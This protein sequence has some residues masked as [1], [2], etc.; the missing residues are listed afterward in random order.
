MDAQPKMAAEG[1]F[2]SILIDGLEGSASDILGNITPAS[3]YALIDQTL[4]PL[5]QRPIYKANVMRFITLRHVAPKVAP[6][7]LRQNSRGIFPL[8]T[9]STR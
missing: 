7:T 9:P 6:E 5:D 3:L 2:T 1:L 4:G 8:Q